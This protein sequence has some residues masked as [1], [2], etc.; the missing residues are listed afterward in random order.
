MQ[1]EVIARKFRPQLFE[2]VVGQDPI[3]Q[4]L[5]N[6]LE[7][8]RIG[9]A[10][11]FSG[12]RGI[13]KTTTARLLAKSLNCA[14]GIT[15][16]PCNRCASCTEVALVRSIDVL[17][18]DAASNT[19]VD[20]VREL[21]ENA[22]Y[23]PSRD[24]YKVF[25]IDEVHMLSA[26]AFNA[27]LKILEEPPAHVVFVMATT[28]RHKIP[29]T[30]LSRCQQFSFRTIPPGK[31]LEHL[32]GIIEQEGVSMSRGALEYT[33]TAADGSM[34]DAQSLLDQIISFGGQQITDEHVRELLGFIPSELLGRTVDAVADCDRKALVEI[35]GALADGGFNLQQYVRQL[36]TR[37]RGLLLIRL[38]LEDS[39]LMSEEHRK[40]LAA[41]AKRFSEQDLIRLVDLV[42]RIENELR[43]TSQPRFHLEVGL[44]KLAQVGHLREIEQVIRELRASDSPQGGGSEPTSA[45]AA[46]SSFFDHQHSLPARA[47]DDRTSGKTEVAPEEP[48]GGRE[49]NGP[50]A[51]VAKRASSDTPPASDAEAENP[52]ARSFRQRFERLV[53]SRS[54]TTSVYLRRADGIEH[55]SGQVE[56]AFSNETIAA[57]L[58][59]RQHRSAL[60]S[61]A[62]DLLGQPTPVSLV[63]TEQP[64][65]RSPRSAAADLAA[66]AREEPL[67]K[68]FLEV[69]GGDVGEVKG[70]G[71][72]PGAED[73]RENP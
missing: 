63:K 56:I 9:H 39:A 73:I 49:S 57:V 6:A 36:L 65:V 11:L 59:S 55:R 13:G 30:V 18:I 71:H 60:E 67:V 45:S 23:V 44:I 19:G 34:R 25:I 24:R 33:V 66:T 5:K 37:L 10:Y 22:R 41:S 28:E 53:D 26:S 50:Q 7:A 31:I 32:E 43:W 40:N 3:T 21:R 72:P 61:A 20:S 68:S 54:A 8:G 64:A 15:A 29:A 17:E 4:T 52:G 70:M 58:A 48:G 69:F 16:S 27:L 12:P 42:V 2:Q 51:A 14:V 46:Q 47:K 38:G 62:S 1:Y 35:V